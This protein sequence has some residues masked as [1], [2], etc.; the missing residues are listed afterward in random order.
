[1]SRDLRTAAIGLVGALIGGVIS[2]FGVIYSEHAEGNRVENRGNER[3]WRRRGYS[4]T[5]I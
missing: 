5:S 1:V 3:R 4:W 2:A